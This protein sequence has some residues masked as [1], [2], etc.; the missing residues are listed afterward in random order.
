MVH[1]PGKTFIQGKN[2]VLGWFLVLSG[3]REIKRSLGLTDRSN[4]SSAGAL[5]YVSLLWRINVN[6]VNLLALTL[7]A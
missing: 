3:N 6:N 1:L 7:L 2:V 5:L 4:I